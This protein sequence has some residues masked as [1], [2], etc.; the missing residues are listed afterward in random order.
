MWTDKNS[1]WGH[2]LRKVCIHCV[3][4]LVCVISRCYSFQM[5]LFLCLKA[6]LFSVYTFSKLFCDSF[7]KVDQFHLVKLI[8][9]FSCCLP[10]FPSCSSSSCFTG[11]SADL[12]G[13]TR[14]SGSM[15][16]QPGSTERFLAQ[17]GSE[18]ASNLSFCGAHTASPSQPGVCVSSL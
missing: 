6:S 17:L 9:S 18:S 4:E 7:L 12:G 13:A 2:T 14:G 10:M 8:K 1:Q 11:P 5:T 16:G 3:P 15:V